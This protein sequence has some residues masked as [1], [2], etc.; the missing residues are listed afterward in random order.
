MHL[1]ETVAPDHDIG[2]AATFAP[3]R[4]AAGFDFD[5]LHLVM[6]E[7][8]VFSR[9]IPRRQKNAAG[10]V[11]MKRTVPD[12]D[13]AGIIS[14]VENE[15]AVSRRERL[16]NRRGLRSRPF[17]FPRPNHRF[18]LQA[19]RS[20]HRRRRRLRR[21]FA[22]TDERRVF[23]VRRSRIPGRPR[24]SSRRPYTAQHPRTARS[25]N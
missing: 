19:A 11:V 3:G 9:N 18:D 22:R 10:A 4:T 12:H 13:V 7:Q 5:R 20:A 23:P 6:P 14:P 25:R 8:I 1:F 15:Q 24:G 17:V 16:R 2:G 21:L